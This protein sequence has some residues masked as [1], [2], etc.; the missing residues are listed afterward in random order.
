MRSNVLVTLF[1]MCAFAS[2]ST[3]QLGNEKEGDTVNVSGGATQTLH[4]SI[5]SVNAGEVWDESGCIRGQA[6]P[7]VKKSIHPDV[8]FRLNSDNHTGTETV[9][10]KHGERLIIKNWGCEYYVL[11]FRFEQE[12]FQGETT[13]TVFWLEKAAVLMS[14][15]EGAIEAPFDIKGGVDKIR[16]YLASLDST[17]YQLGEEIVLEDDV[18]RDF[19]TLDRIERINEK[20]FAV[21]ISFATGPL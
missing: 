8:V 7:V 11:T 14:E 10:L 4:D 19:I 2:C 18:M 5:D 9:N 20:K 6:E 21:E 13:N 15:I 1:A 12:R 16:L 17:A 3:K